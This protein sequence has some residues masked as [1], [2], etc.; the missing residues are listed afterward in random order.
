MGNPTTKICQFRGRIL[1]LIPAN[2]YIILF[3]LVS[4]LSKMVWIG[5]KILEN[6][7]KCKNR[8]TRDEIIQIYSIR[9]HRTRHHPSTAITSS[10]HPNRYW[11]F[12][13][14]LRLFSSWLISA[15]ILSLHFIAATYVSRYCSLTTM[16]TNLAHACRK[17]QLKWTTVG[18]TERTKVPWKSRT[19]LS[20]IERN[21]QLSIP[22]RVSGRSIIISTECR[23]QPFRLNMNI[24]IE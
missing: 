24:C 22:W 14:V 16:S 7:I 13:T 15:N 11:C 9:A 21:R 18:N 1:K 3:D 5:T 8:E 10:R 12:V 4:T 17:V 20:Q 6:D 19:I 23:L 2:N